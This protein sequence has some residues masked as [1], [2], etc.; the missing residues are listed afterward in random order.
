[1]QLDKKSQLMMKMIK[2]KSKDKLKFLIK[3][4]KNK[5]KSY[6]ILIQLTRLTK[7]K[8]KKILILQYMLF[9]Q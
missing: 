6:P 9:N 4:L 3:Y 8:L 5:I 7:P 1:M 2:L